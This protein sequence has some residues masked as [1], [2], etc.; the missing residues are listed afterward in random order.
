MAEIEML[1]IIGISLSFPVTVSSD[2]D[3]DNPFEKD[4]VLCIFKHRSFVTFA[5]KVF[6]SCH[7][8]KGLK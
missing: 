1:L 8:N 7:A 5:G 6:F 4:H 3:S 2:N